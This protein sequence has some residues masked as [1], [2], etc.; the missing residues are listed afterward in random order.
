MEISCIN[1]WGWMK[2]RTCEQ[3]PLPC[4]GCFA[5]HPLRHAP[6]VAIENAAERDRVFDFN[7]QARFKWQ[8]RELL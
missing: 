3:K 2:K 8:S 1:P 5:W 4:D 6:M 7:N